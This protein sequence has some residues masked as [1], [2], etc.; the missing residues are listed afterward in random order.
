MT[1]L[2]R[3]DRPTRIVLV[4]V[5]LSA[6][7]G[8]VGAVSA[9]SAITTIAIVSGGVSVLTSGGTPGLLG[10]A[11]GFGAFCG[12]LGAPMLGWGLL[13][14][15][16]LGRAILCTAVGTILGAVGGELLQPINLFVQSLP[17][18]LAG[19]FI[20][21]VSAGIGLRVHSRLTQSTSV[22]GA[23]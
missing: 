11:A 1:T 4:T 17:G 21:F 18:V 3:T 8:L 23:V 5:G 13:R 14:R 2:E 15:V 19:A 20:G 22:D 12:I 6:T 16:P 9:A 10:A 7:G